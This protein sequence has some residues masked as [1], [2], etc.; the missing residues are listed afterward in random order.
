MAEEKVS[1]QIPSSV[2]EPTGMNGHKEQLSGEVFYPSPEVVKQARIKDW[3]AVS[4]FAAQDLQ[5][6]W[7]K[8]ADELD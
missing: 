3:E 8:E 6:F 7:A 4:K 5:G 1:T 2:A